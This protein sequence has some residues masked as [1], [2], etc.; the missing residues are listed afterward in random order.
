MAS[1][2]YDINTQQSSTFNFHIEY[3]DA[4]GDPVDLTGYTARLQVRPNTTSSRL[5]LHVSNGEVISGGTAG[6]FGATGGMVGVGG[7]YLNKGSTGATALGGILVSADA[8]SMSNV[9][10]GTWVY[11]LDLTKDGK[12]EEILNGRFVVA[13]KITRLG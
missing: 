7:I 12:T 11:S 3:Y 8:I 10:A 13:P 2:Y 1:A 4:D 5:Y 6:D 9:R